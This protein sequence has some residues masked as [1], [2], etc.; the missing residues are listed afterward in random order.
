MNKITHSMRLSK[1]A[2]ALT[3]ALCLTSPAHAD[4][5][6]KSFAEMLKAVPLIPAGSYD[7]EML[8]KVTNAVNFIKQQDLPQAQLAI[9]EALQL[10]ARNSHLHFLNGFVYH[11]QARQGDTQKAEMALEG[12]QQALRIDPSNWIA[13]EFLGLAY[14]DLKQFDNAKLAFSD[15]LLLTP[16]SSVSIYGLMVSS[17]L[18]GDA[19]TACAMADQ[20]QKTSMSTT[21]NRGFIRSS[22][23]VYASC[24]NFAQ[25]DRMR[26]N[27][28]K[29]TNSGP[30]VERV[31]RRLA[32]WKSFYLKQEQTTANTKTPAGGMMKTSLSD[33]PV[34]G[35]PVQLAQAFTSSAPAYRPPP[36]Q[37]DPVADNQASA[38]E[39]LAVPV[40]ATPVVTAAADAAGSGPRMLLIDV[41]LLSTQELMATS[42]GINLLNALTL[43]LGSGTTA[44]YSRIVTSNSLN[45]ATPDVSTA[46]TRAVSIPALSYSLNIANANSSVNEVL[47]RPTLA[48]IEGLPSE[49]FSGT[50]LSAGLV[51]TSQQ[52]GTTIVPLDK[53][54]G[55]K[56]SVTP[57]FLPQGRVQLKIEAQRTAL[58]ASSET[59]RVAYQ[60][61]IGELTANANVVMNLGET[62]LLSGLSEKTRT[63]TRDGV[64]GLQDVPVVQYLFSNKKTNDLQ[65]SALILITPRA[66]IQIA[67]DA[68]NESRSMALRMKELREKF[69]FANNNPANIEA[70]MTQLQSNQFFREFR[71]GDVAMERWDRMRTTGD[72]LE[73]ALSFLYY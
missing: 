40:A 42:K 34:N 10:D 23:S 9:N 67:D 65:R 54:F 20:F 58:N 64:P 26:D 31:D 5:T 36:R 57:T 52:G 56:L 16:E 2:A 70:V 59:S 63:S 60:I 66:P 44:A 19:R 35:R 45:G 13:K 17:Y 3:M 28:S 29:L 14:M 12:Y 50:N 4:E 47:A 21:A 55:I 46:I 15:V 41:V 38:A 8:A 72:R 11:L 48:A 25:A 7:S 37:E 71:Q 62:L 49:F 24:G 61:E 51:S 6:A 18:T 73:E 30:E 33:Y 32:Q 1:I 53:R 22:V 69:G 43:Q 27:L 39:P 68:A